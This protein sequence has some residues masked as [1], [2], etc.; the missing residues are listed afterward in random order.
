MKLEEFKVKAEKYTGYDLVDIS[1]DL[2][3]EIFCPYC[4]K[5]Y[6][7]DGYFCETEGEWIYSQCDACE[8]VFKWQWYQT[9]VEFESEEIED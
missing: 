2:D 3:G 6:S 1:P 8:E 5:K 9:G 4:G 7:D